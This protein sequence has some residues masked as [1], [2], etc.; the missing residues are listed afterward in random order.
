MSKHF[1][2]DSLQIQK[3][4]EITETATS[5]VVPAVITREAV[6]EYDFGPCYQPATVVKKASFSA[7]DAWIVENHPQEII[8]SRVDDLRGK[9]RDPK[10]QSGR[11]RANLEFFKDRCSPKYLEG[12]RS[13]DIRSV[14]IG[15]FY[16]TKEES[17]VW[18]GEEYDHVKTHLFIDHVAVGDWTGRCSYPFCGIGVDN[19]GLEPGLKLGAD[20]YPDEHACR[21]RDPDTLEIVG[22]G[23][24]SHEGKKY[25]VIYGRPKGKPKAGSV[26]QA[27]R[28]PKKTWSESEARAH[29]KS[30]KGEFEPAAKEKAQ[31]SPSRSS[32]GA[33]PGRAGQPDKSTYESPKER[34][35]ESGV[36]GGVESHKDEKR[37]TENSVDELISRAEKAI[38][39]L[40][41]C[42]EV[43]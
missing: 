4:A 11:I 31:S 18:N 28:Y 37:A 42:M 14:S 19:P 1:G 21:L 36:E 25:R 43:M 9:V 33:T 8:V 3:D 20:P 22:S 24:R 17:G 40:E 30:H 41:A 6:L 7:L 12:I 13:G 34:W 39:E 15:F 35:I 2:I 29:C 10:F 16:D 5:L 23:T 26:E 38:R 27:Y 32:D